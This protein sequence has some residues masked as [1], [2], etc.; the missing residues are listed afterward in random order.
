MH[1]VPT[2][3]CNYPSR[4]SH[5]KYKKHKKSYSQYKQPIDIIVEKS[6]ENIP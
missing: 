4:F 2:L 6:K 3:G 5:K 1:E